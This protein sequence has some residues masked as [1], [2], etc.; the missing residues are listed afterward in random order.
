MGLFRVFSPYG[1]LR[2]H[3]RGTG[4]HDPGR[5]DAPIANLNP[6]WLINLGGDF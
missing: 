1:I 3:P 6:N 2:M 4:R 5:F